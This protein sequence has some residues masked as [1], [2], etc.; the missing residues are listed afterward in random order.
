MIPPASVSEFPRGVDVTG[1]PE[2]P[3][4]GAELV[5]SLDLDP[6]PL[7]FEIAAPKGVIAKGLQPRAEAQGIGVGALLGAFQGQVHDFIG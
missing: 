3:A 1:I 6:H 5:R 7:F 4:A 2:H